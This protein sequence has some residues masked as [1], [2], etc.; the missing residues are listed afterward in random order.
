MAKQYWLMKSE[1]DE[2]GIDDLKRVDIEPW[3]GV[4]NYQARNF[5]R[6]EMKIGDEILFYHSSTNPAGVAGVATVASEPYPDPTQFNKKSAYYDEKSTEEKPR[7][8][9]IDVKFKKKLKH[10]V[11]LSAMKEEASLSQMKVLQKGNRLSIIPVSKEDF[12]YILKM[13]S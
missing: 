7:W 10:F 3:S 13:G 8:I 4:R 6:D 5:M 1:P 2:F 12:Q 9:L 11:S